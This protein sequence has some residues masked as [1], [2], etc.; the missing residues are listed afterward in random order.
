M[1]RRQVRYEEYA[2]S[3]K[4]PKFSAATSHQHNDA[5]M[6]AFDEG[7]EA[8]KINEQPDVVESNQSKPQQQP[9]CAIIEKSTTSLE[10]M[11][12]SSWYS[13][14]TKNPSGI[15]CNVSNQPLVCMT[16]KQP[17]AVVGSTDHA[18]YVIDITTGK[19]VRTLYTKRFGHAEWV[20]C[21]DHMDDGRIVSGAMDSKLCIWGKP[22][23]KIP[24]ATC[25]DAIGHA[26][27]ISSVKTLGNNAI[28]SASYDRTIR[29][30]EA[31]HRSV[32]ET[33]VL[34]GHKA[35]I[36]DINYHDNYLISGDRGGCAVRWDLNSQRVCQKL[37]NAH[38]GHVTVVKAG[39]LENVFLTGGQDGIVKVWDFR[40]KNA[41]FK[42]PLHTSATSGTGALCAIESNEAGGDIVTAGA[43]HLVN[44]IDP[45][46]SFKTRSVFD[47]HKDFI[48]SLKVTGGLAFSGAGDGMLL[49]HDI[50]QGKLLYGLGANQAAVR[51]I[52][53]TKETLVAAGDDGGVIVYNM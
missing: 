2:A 46:A 30:W 43:D 23:E 45:K 15:S 34:K 44:V 33:A 13:G 35:P 21:V 6:K 39:I 5:Y 36:L 10:F 27:S 24:T 31:K 7:F 48:Y 18:L 9:S 25:I 22:N 52:G 53:M 20:N 29:L 47:D 19:K 37:A 42:L 17:Y 51:C 11:P 26:G 28:V 3:K 32:E 1:P 4:P 50:Q 41:V 38:D 16:I 49:V 40:N 12:N 14:P 8:L